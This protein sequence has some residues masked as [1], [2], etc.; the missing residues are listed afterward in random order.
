[1]SNLTI[2]T[3]HSYA[4]GPM[5]LNL[6]TDGEF[7]LEGMPE[8]GYLHRGIEKLA[9]K[10]SWVGFL[11]FTDRLDYVSSVHGNLVYALA[12][13]ALSNIQ[14][15][16]RASRI[17]VLVSELSRI[18]SHL[19]SI[20]NTAKYMGS[21]TLFMYALRDREKIINLFEMLA[22]S[23]LTHSFVRIGGVAQDIT[24]GFLE[25]AQD[26]VEYFMPKL[27]EYANL[28]YEQEIVR[29][30]LSG[31]AVVTKE[32]AIQCG[33]SGPNARA[34]GLLLD[35]RKQFPYSNYS[36]YKFE[37]PFGAGVADGIMGDS[38]DRFHVRFQEIAESME[39]VKQGLKN[40]PKGDFL[41]PIPRI[42]KVKKGETYQA[43]ESPRGHLG[44]YICS[45][46]DRSPARVRF[47]TPS[48]NTLSLF[49][50][51]LKNIQ[52]S[53]VA[54]AVSSFDI[55]MSEVDR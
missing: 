17:R 8:V 4:I 41:T 51:V 31:I 18:Q 7:V 55:L 40:I 3:N 20:G 33:L 50:K 15:S 22:G 13:E 23:R 48:F 19:L 38:F 54:T 34:S 27:K 47:K 52:L 46:G 1:M 21:R 49:P 36:D 32:F 28:F 53:D 43:V 24:E 30:R 37:A 25:K 45:N 29:G 26:F 12:V 5:K 14:V 11:P 6:K 44:I 9:E 16:P 10:I 35:V 2:E 42:F 39:I